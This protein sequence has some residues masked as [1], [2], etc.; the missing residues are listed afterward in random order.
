MF[1][2]MLNEHAQVYLTLSYTHSVFVSF[3]YGVSLALAKSELR[4]N[5]THWALD[6]Y[7]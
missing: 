7:M 3:L 2:N 1:E 6:C 5:C 4:R